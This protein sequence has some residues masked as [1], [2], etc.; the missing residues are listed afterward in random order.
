MRT[1]K[2]RDRHDN[3]KRRGS[4]LMRTR[5]KRGLCVQTVNACWQLTAKYKYR[6][7]EADV[8]L[9]GWHQTV[10]SSFQVPVITPRLSYS[11][12]V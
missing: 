12:N 4:Q 3:C 5:L 6:N 9:V 2:R 7:K 1:D 8:S 10:H 11:N